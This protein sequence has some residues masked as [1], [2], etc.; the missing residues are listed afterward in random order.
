MKIPFDVGKLD[1]LMAE[2]GLSL[3]LAHTR[4]NVRYLSGGYYYHFHANSTRMGRSQYLPFVGIPRGRIGEAFYVA[5]DEE[6]GQL[7]AEPPWFPDAH[8]G[9]PRNGDRGRGRRE[10]RCGSWA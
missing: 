9:G 6:R 1:R 10:R 2:A 7:E 3:V 8:R 5:R 4:H